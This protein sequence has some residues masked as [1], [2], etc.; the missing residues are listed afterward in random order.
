[1]P[2]V[3]EIIRGRVLTQVGRQPDWQQRLFRWAL[4]IGLKR[5]E[6]RRLN[7]GEYLLDPLLDRLVRAKVRDR[8]GGRLKAAMSGGARLE[9]EVGLFYL[10]L[11]LLI[12]QGYGQTEAGPVISANP[13]TRSASIRSVA[14]WRASNCASPRTAKSWCAAIW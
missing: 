13:R 3:L 5:I 4:D 1:M 2:R 11:G 10:A 7:L 6:G 14:C 9:P 8:F 12:M